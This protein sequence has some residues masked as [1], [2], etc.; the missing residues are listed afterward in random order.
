MKNN[1]FKVFIGILIFTFYGIIQ[2]DPLSVNVIPEFNAY[3]EGDTVII[4]LDVQIEDGHHLYSNPLGPGIGIPLEISVT[5]PGGIEWFA[6]QKEE[7]IRFTPDFGDWV[8]A[9]N[10][11]AESELFR[12][13]IDVALVHLQLWHCKFPVL[14]MTL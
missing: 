8:W 12:A 14:S 3:T 1:F 11:V 5:K 7:P 6:L 2:A 10:N 9:C 13:A 4:A